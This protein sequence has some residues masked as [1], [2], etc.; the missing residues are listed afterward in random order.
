MLKV[1]LRDSLGGIFSLGMYVN[2]MHEYCQVEMVL[3]LSIV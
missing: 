1:L 2:V 3:L